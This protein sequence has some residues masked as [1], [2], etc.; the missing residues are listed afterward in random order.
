MSCFILSWLTVGI[1]CVIYCI[2]HDAVHGVFIYDAKCLVSIMI[3][4][5]LGYISLAIII[6]FTIEDFIKKRK[7]EI[8]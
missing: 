4:T 8:E 5:L 6:K 3:M 7:G 1:I 2:I